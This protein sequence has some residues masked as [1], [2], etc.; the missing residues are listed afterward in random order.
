MNHIYKNKSFLFRAEKTF[1]DL[2]CYFFAN[3]LCYD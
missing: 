3:I 1:F 2:L